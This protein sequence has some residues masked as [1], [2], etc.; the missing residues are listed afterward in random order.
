MA[1]ETGDEAKQS[2]A[3]T[4]RLNGEIDRKLEQ[5]ARRERVSINVVASQAI[6]RYVEFDS[7]AKNVGLQV[8]ANRLL[9]KLIDHVPEDKVREIGAWWANNIGKEI[10]SYLF[11]NEN[12]R[13]FNQTLE[14]LNSYGGSF[15]MERSTDRNTETLILSHGLGEKWSLFYEQA[16]K[17]WLE[18]FAGRELDS[19]KVDHTENQVFA[20]IK[21]PLSRSE[22]NRPPV[23]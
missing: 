21:T 19:F 4:I 10:A 15:E 9:E 16:L 11:K 20:E 7:V 2:T 12:F 18:R 23:G 8:V 13:T 6:R 3:R 17:S 5:L 22:S 14:A 1:L